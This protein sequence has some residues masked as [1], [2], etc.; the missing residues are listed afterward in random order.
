MKRDCSQYLLGLKAIENDQNKLLSPLSYF[1]PVK[2]RLV[3]R[4]T[5]CNAVHKMW[6]HTLFRLHEDLEASQDNVLV[7]F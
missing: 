6:V 7:A 3:D 5:N 2:D 4:C 1:L